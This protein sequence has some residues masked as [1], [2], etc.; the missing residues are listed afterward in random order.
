MR[1]FLYF[2]ILVVLISC[3]KTVDPNYVVKTFD[4]DNLGFIKTL[5]SKKHNVIGIKNPRRIL[6]Y[7][8]KI[9]LSES[10]VDTMIHC[11]SKKT[12][13]IT[14]S[15][16]I[17]GKGPGEIPSMPWSMFETSDKETFGVFLLSS[18]RIALFD[19]NQ[20]SSEAK[21]V[22]RLKY[23]A[24]AAG[25]ATLSTDTTVM[26]IPTNN[27]NKFIEFDFHGNKIDSF[28][29][30]SNMIE[31]EVPNS[32][33]FSLHQG[34]ISTNEKRDFFGLACIAV[35]RIELLN[36]NTRKQ[37]SI[38]GPIHHM[39][40][41]NVDNSQGYPMLA[42]P[43]PEAKYCYTGIFMGERLVYALFSNASYLDVNTGKR[44][45]NEIYVFDYEGDVQGKYLLDVDITQFTVD[46]KARKF[47]G[48]SFD[49]DPNIVVFDFG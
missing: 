10:G 41:F 26:T 40:R 17:L 11:I 12:F 25:A 44:F 49:L 42:I 8:D 36:K 47:Y 7:N 31:R 21:K 5:E 18:H 14:N 33:I 6:S 16:G 27:E 35:D 29:I 9:I 34:V 15:M 32:I 24:Q 1:A 48:I 20:K 3:N 13:Q 19:L 43:D 23:Q 2:G 46:E 22:I 38:R 4:D 39:P 37:I 45:C 30:W 28:G